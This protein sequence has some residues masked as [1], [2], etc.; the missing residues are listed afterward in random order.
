MINQR[1]FES[2]VVDKYEIDTSNTIN[3]QIYKDREEVSELETIKDN[4]TY[5]LEDDKKDHL[6]YLFSVMKSVILKVQDII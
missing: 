5:N 1:V 4:S 6:D 3:N 2:T